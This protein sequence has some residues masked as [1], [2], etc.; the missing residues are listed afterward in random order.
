MKTS[1][2]FLA[3]GFILLPWCFTPLFS[4]HHDSDSNKKITIIKHTVEADGTEVTETIVKKG[5]AAEDFDV[6]QYVREN[7]NDQN[8]VEVIVR[9]GDDDN[10]FFNFGNDNH[11]IFCISGDD[12]GAFLGVQEDSDEDGNEAGLVVQIVRGSAADQAGLRDN[13]K[14]L[15]LNDVK[16]DKWSDLS[17]FIQQAKLG[18]KVNIT[19]SRNDKTATTEATL[20]TRKAIKCEIKCE[21]KGFLGVSDNDEDEAAAGVAVSITKASGAANAG[22]ENGDVIF[23]LNDT[24]IADF[25]DI[26]DFMAYTKPGD[27]VQVTYERDGQRKTVEAILGAQNKVDIQD[28]NFE[29]PHMEL[30]GLDHV[31]FDMNNNFNYEVKQKEACLGVYSSENEDHGAAIQSFTGE[32]A[33]AEAGMQEGDVILSVNNQMVNGHSELWD[34]IAK[35]KTGEKVNVAYEREG[36]PMQIQATLKACK[37]KSRVDIFDQSGNDQIRRFYTWGWD[38]ENQRQMR[39]TRIIIIRRAGEGDGVN[40]APKQPVQ[41][42]NLALQSFRAFPNPSEG[43]ITVEFKGEPVETVVSLFDLAGRQLFREELNAFNGEYS[44]QFDLTAY[45]KGTIII[46]VQQKDQVYTEQIIVQ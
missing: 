1:T 35:Y 30:K 46:H 5:K 20:S 34:E 13:D 31:N 12:N 6:D 29:A 8:Q 42:R 10:I 36:A 11:N 19:Y 14:I 45:A 16:T 2:I 17:E 24:Q 22:L 25:E 15:Q 4:Q 32:S 37:D 38:N 28:F 7:E 33:A 18:D 41:N 27:K 9:D 39:E 40:P 21:P 23:Q 43:Q 44:Q 26:T 3:L